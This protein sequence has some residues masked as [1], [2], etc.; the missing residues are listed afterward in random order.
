MMATDGAARAAR[1]AR[2]FLRREKDAVDGV[3]GA[4][5]SGTEQ[6]HDEPATK[7]QAR[8][9]RARERRTPEWEE[10]GQ[11]TELRVCGVEDICPKALHGNALRG[12]GVCSLTLLQSRHA[13]CRWWLVRGCRVYFDTIWRFVAC[14]SLCVCCCAVYVRVGN[15][16]DERACEMR[17]GVQML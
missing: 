5:D 11:R 14:L 12:L 10:R 17:A 3:R 13:S 16:K 15:A 6:W 9:V 1:A 2:A 7:R 8:W 4:G